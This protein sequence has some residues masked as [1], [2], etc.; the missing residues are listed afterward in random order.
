MWAGLPACLPCCMSVCLPAYLSVGLSACFCLPT[1]PPSVC[2]SVCL[3][4]CLSVSANLLPTHPSFCLPLYRIPAW[5]ITNLRW[6][7]GRLPWPIGDASHIQYLHCGPSAEWQ[8]FPSRFNLWVTVAGWQRLVAFIKQ[9]NW[10][11][12]QV[13]LAEKW[14]PS[15]LQWI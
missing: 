5:P 8:N 15:D 7:E 4:P 2:L 11:R 6:K 10:R 3:P 14:I 13:H 1:H 9:Y 12:S